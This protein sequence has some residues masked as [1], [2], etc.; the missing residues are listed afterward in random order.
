MVEK[1]VIVIPTHSSYIDICENFVD[2]IK[3]NWSDCPYKIVLSVFGENKKIEGIDTI[4]NEASASITECLVNVTQKYKAKVYLSFLGDA[5]IARKVDD[6]II[7]MFINEFLKYEIEYCR[8]FAQKVRFRRIKVGHTM[9][10]LK[11]VRYGMSFVAFAATE[12]FIL[13]EFGN[14][15]TDLDF[16]LKYLD[17]AEKTNGK[18]F[19]NTKTMLAK[20]YFHIIPGIEKGKWDRFALYRLRKSNPTICF[21]DREKISLKWELYLILRKIYLK[22]VPLQV[23]LGTKKMLKKIFKNSFVTDK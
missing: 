11:S 18:I 3:N 23:G 4:F 12:D 2:L 5:F 1:C 14:G 7:Q 6:S 21:S 15:E 13:K 9:R 10:K 20:N 16:E 19:S 17:I 22:I 8:L